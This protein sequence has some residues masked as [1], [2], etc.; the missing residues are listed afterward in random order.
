MATER[1]QKILS[2]AGVS[3]R[4]TAEALILEGRVAVN[5]VVVTE[6]G[7]RADTDTDEVTVDGV[8]ANRGRYRYVLMNKPSGVVTTARDEMGRPTVVDLV[9]GAREQG[10]YPVGRLDTTSEGLLL[11]TNDG[12]LTNF[13]THPRYGV[14][15]EYLVR[16]DG[17]LAGR[18]MQRMT[19]GVDSEGERLHAH[20]VNRVAPPG[21]N[22][23]EPWLRVVLREGKNREIRRML[24]IFGRRAVTLRRMRMGPLHLGTL[25]RGAWRELTPAEVAELYANVQKPVATP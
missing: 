11:L 25:G 12:H 20:S 7:S 15:K 22:A 21:A 14:E 8:P 23:A 10:L 3:S 24:D 17:P 13:L 18:D 19:R 5:G 16:L 9:P 1:L 2:H 6:L 4:R